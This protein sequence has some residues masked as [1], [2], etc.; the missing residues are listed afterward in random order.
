MRKVLA[1]FW[2]PFSLKKRRRSRR[3]LNERGI[4]RLRDVDSIE[5]HS[6]ELRDTI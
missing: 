6:I 2:K 3:I 1:D 5:G 4:K